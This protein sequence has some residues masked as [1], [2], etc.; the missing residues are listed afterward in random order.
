[1]NKICEYGCGKRALYSPHKGTRKWCC[2]DNWQKCSFIRKKS[3]KRTVGKN[4]PM[5]GKNHTE[6]TKDKISRKLIRE[7]NPNFGKRGSNSYMFGKN[8]SKQTKNKMS[9]QRLGKNNPM[10]GKNHTEETKDK[11]RNLINKKERSINTKNS[12]IKN[13]ELI[14][15]RRVKALSLRKD[16]N[17]RNK[18]IISIKN[19]WKRIDVINKHKRTIERIKEKYP[20]F[21]KIEDMRY[22]P[23]KVKVKEIQVRCKNNKCINSKENNGWFTPTKRQIEARLSNVYSNLL[24]DGCY[25]YCSNK[26]KKECKL[27]RKRTSQLIR[28]I[29]IEVGT[30]EGEVPIYTSEEYQTFRKHVLKLDNNKCLYCNELAEHVHH[31]RPQ[32]LEPFFTLDPDLAISCCRECHYK[33]GHKDECAQI[34]I[35]NKICEGM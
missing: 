12:Y 14:E 4:N 6:E 17:F 19:S 29:E 24:G 5:F 34:Q 7:K 3:H 11:I 26:C 30:Y 20:I 32:K 21:Y 25:F 28:E 9:K 1:M 22:N 18:N 35:A 13:P 16:E 15:K 23:K 31:T 2:E 27:Y 33:Y 8:H 10:F